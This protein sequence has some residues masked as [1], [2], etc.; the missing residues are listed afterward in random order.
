MPSE[1]AMAMI[2]VVSA[3]SSGSRSMSAMKLRSIFTPSTGTRR[4]WLSP[5]KP[6]PK[7]SSHTF[8]PVRCSVASSALACASSLM[9]A[10]S[11]SS[12]CRRD[13]ARPV[14]RRHSATTSG[15]SPLRNWRGDTLTETNNG[16]SASRSVLQRAAAAQAARSTRGPMLS[17]SPLCSATSMNTDGATMPSSGCCQRNNA[18]APT[19]R[20]SAMRNTGWYI[21]LSSPRSH[22]PRSSCSMR[23]RRSTAWSIARL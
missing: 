9:T 13:A 23:T 15:R 21:R 2:A 10:V 14:S 11:V 6:V 17:I 16:S 1:C 8:T 22:A 7:S 5:E 12:R 19:M 4:R 18:S 20:L 3:R